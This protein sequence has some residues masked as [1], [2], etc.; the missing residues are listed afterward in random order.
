MNMCKD[1][2]KR[3]KTGPMVVGLLPFTCTF[4]CDSDN[5]EYVNV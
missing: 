2:A 5:L 3:K 4:Q 1:V